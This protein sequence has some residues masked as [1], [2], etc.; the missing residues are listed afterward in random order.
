VPFVHVYVPGGAVEIGGAI[1]AP[2]DTG[3]RR[4]A[5]TT[6]RSNCANFLTQHIDYALDRQRKD[7][8]ADSC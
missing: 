6:I 4:P 3:P 7:S 2:R 1:L 5:I 8:D